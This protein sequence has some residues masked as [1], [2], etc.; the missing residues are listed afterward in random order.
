MSSSTDP[1]IHV[2]DVLRA[3]AAT[4]LTDGSKAMV[5][6]VVLADGSSANLAMSHVVAARLW[7]A[8]NGRDVTLLDPP[9]TTWS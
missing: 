4:D 9:P 2:A 5:V 8:L 7:G 6:E 1:L 3:W